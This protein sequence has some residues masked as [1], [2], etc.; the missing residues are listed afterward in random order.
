MTELELLRRVGAHAEPSPEQV[1]A[2]AATAL[3]RLRAAIADEVGSAAA[4]SQQP[5]PVRRWWDTLGASPLALAGAAAFTIAVVAAVSLTL[6]TL[7]PRPATAGLDQLAAAAES[8]DE[9]APSAGEFVYTRSEV[10]SVV[11]EV[12]GGEVISFLR[13]QTVERWLNAD[14]QLRIRRSSGA[15]RFFSADAEAA[16]QAAGLDAAY[17]AGTVDDNVFE[18]AQVPETRLA[19]WSTNPAELREQMVADIAP[20]ATAGLPRP[21]RMLEL[22]TSLL[23]AT[24]ASAELRAAV[25]RVLADEAGIQSAT[26]ADGSVVTVSVA[27]ERDGRGFTHEVLF[28]ADTSHIVQE[29]VVA[30]DDLPGGIPAGT[31]MRSRVNEPSVRVPSIEAPPTTD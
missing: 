8:A 26:A 3:T 27:Y 19:D 7:R 12:V 6:T 23:Q 22:G 20:G 24:G 4:G 30:T 13:P 15:P 17:A 2:A 1:E 5:G 16:F 14:G 25:L 18:P 11:Q 9:P 10:S 28:E 31:V 29:S 21:A